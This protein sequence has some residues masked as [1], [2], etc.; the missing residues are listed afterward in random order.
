MISVLAAW[1]GGG[2]GASTQ[3]ADGVEQLTS[4]ADNGDPHVLEVIRCK[5]GQDLGVDGVVTE[6][7]LVLA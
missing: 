1:D 7:L 3:G 6:R 4:V 5:P 2:L